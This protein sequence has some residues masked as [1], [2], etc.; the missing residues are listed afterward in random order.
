MF[1]D[2]NKHIRI[3]ILSYSVYDV[4]MRVKRYAETLGNLGISVD[5][6]ALYRNEE[7]K[8]DNHQNIRIFR[9]MKRKFNEKKAIN[10]AI[11]M[12]AFFVKSFILLSFK[13]IKN[14]YDVIHV[15]NPPDFLIFAAILPKWFG[16]KIILDMHENIPELYSIK[17]NC[18]NDGPIIKSLIWMERLATNYADIVLAAH[19]LLKTRIVNRDNIPVDRCISILNY[20]QLD[21][22]SPVNK[23][24]ENDVIRIIYPGTISYHH[25]IDILIKA[26]SIIKGKGYLVRLDIYA[27]STNQKYLSEVNGLIKESGLETDIIFH[28]PVPAHRI[29]KIM[30]ES[31]IGVVPKRAGAFGSEAFS[32][33]ILEFM[34]VGVPVIASRTKIEEYYFDESQIRFFEPENFTELAECVIQ[35]CNDRAKREE[36]S[37][38][39]IKYVSENN[40]ENKKQIYLDSVANLLTKSPTKGK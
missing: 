19:D 10:Y 36:L 3:G 23:K 34:A 8:G 9:I 27:T 26:I 33:K 17:F 22:F 21:K 13:H 11:N 18:N 38:N 37:K 16:S 30:A 25:G 29:G 39:G 24:T 14:N 28:G 12:I 20:P 2:L 1:Q 6:F 35:L 31:D 4:D 32:T 40:W 5:V 15:N 7:I